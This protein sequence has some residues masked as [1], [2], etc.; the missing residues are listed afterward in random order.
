[1]RDH[2]PRQPHDTDLDLTV[3]LQACAAATV[4]YPAVKVADVLSGA[5]PLPI[6]ALQ[7]LD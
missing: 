1:M 6:Q 3:L 7:G 5:V 4:G 2:C